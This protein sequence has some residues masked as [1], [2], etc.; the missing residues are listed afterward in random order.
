[1]LDYLLVGLL[2][3]LIALGE[4]ATRYRDRPLV[5]LRVPGP[6]VYV[7]VN[8]AASIGALALIRHYGWTFDLDGEAA[9]TTRILIAGFGAMAVLRSAL[10]VVR[11]GDR[12]VP[13]GPGAFL[14]GLAE[15]A[16]SAIARSVEKKHLESRMLLAQ[17]G[18]GGVPF[19]RVRVALPAYALALSGKLSAED[20]S[21]LA[22]RVN[23]IG[24]SNVPE[25]MKIV[26]LG[27]LL[28]EVVGEDVFEV[29]IRAVETDLEQG[30]R[31]GVDAADGTKSRRLREPNRP[32]ASTPP[33]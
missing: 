22:T 13:V 30:A 11:V 23:E 9:R 6:Y 4:L 5:A 28:I 32:T 16:D 2:G 31:F 7:G 20:Q 18:V 12:D 17:L 8:V 15:V 25:S 10:F 33:Q 24:A 14:S 26:L 29:A 21:E 27:T 1:V 19:E 3:G